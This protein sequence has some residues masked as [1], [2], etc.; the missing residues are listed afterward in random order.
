MSTLYT[1]FY[2]SLLS[3]IETPTFPNKLHGHTAEKQIKSSS[4][5]QNVSELHGYD[6]TLLRHLLSSDKN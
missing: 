5:H 4:R 6:L 1:V 2:L 3:K